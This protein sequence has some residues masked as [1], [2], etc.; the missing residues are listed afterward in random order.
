FIMVGGTVMAYMGGLHF[1]WPKITGRMYPDG[2][3]RLSAAI[4]FVG[5][6]LT[7]LPQFVLGYVGM[8][9]RY[10]T[11]PAAFHV[12]NVLSSARASMLG[13]GYVLPFT[14]LIWSLGYGPKAGSNPWGA[15][16]LEWQTPS[17]PPPENF[18]QTPV[19]TCGPYAYHAEEE[20][21]VVG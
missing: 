3:A 13:V 7:F 10:A 1:W 14:Y 17:P 9:R 11:Y 21:D 16:G 20:P 6:F 2:W 15:T 19:V 4:I 5:F 8:P 12:L 18:A